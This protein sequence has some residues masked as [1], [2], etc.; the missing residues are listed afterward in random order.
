VVDPAKALQELGR[1]Q[2]I[3]A[4]A[5][6]GASMSPLIDGLG[7]RGRWSR[8]LRWKKQVRRTSG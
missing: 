3:V 8:S 6:S 2:V 7:L 4:T 1:A 5:A